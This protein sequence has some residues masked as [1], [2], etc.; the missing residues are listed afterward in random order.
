MARAARREAGG[1]A[2]RTPPR[3]APNQFAGAHERYI[4]QMKGSQVGFEQFARRQRAAKTVHR[5][6]EQ[7]RSE[8][9]ACNSPAIRRGPRVQ[10][11]KELGMRPKKFGK[12]RRGRFAG[13]F[14]FARQLFCFVRRR[15]TCRDPPGVQHHDNAA[16]YRSGA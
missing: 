5:T 9:F 1:N 6:A 16:R 11:R 10:L 3:P 4:F 14:C 12:A 8:L 15:L 13:H 2:P 7:R